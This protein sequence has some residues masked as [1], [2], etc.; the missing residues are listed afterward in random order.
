MSKNITHWS[1][2]D[3]KRR[4]R[5]EAGYGG[6]GLHLSHA[7]KPK[8]TNPITQAVSAGIKIV[9]CVCDLPAHALLV[10]VPCMGERPMHEI[11]K[12]L[13]GTRS[14]THRPCTG[15]QSCLRQT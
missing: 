15:T 12:L 7:C 3:K 14:R 9:E 8:S 2:I 13:V 5:R 11:D 10:V 1:L 6:F 4:A